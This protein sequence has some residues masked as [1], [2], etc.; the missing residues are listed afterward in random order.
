MST[1]ATTAPTTSRGRSRRIPLAVTISAWAAPLLVIGDF[2][3]MAV[4]PVG[5][6]VNAAVRDPRVRYLRWP[7]ALLAAAY[8]TP[9]TIFLANP[10]RAGSLSKDID[11][12]FVGLIVVASVVLL[13][14]LYTGSR[15]VGQARKSSP[16][17]R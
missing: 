3:L 6:L 4:I 16:V 15:R 13:V 12:V 7:I 11:P 14:R 1:S 9:L 10:D 2:A 8:A 5:L 17:S